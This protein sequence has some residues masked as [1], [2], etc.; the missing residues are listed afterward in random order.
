LPAEFRQ[1]KTVLQFLI[2]DILIFD[3]DDEAC[4]YS[5]HLDDGAVEWLGREADVPKEILE[6]V[7]KICSRFKKA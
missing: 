2:H 6:E 4:V 7:I 1:S 5:G 3:S